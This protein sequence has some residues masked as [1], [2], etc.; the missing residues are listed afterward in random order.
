VPGPGEDPPVGPSPEVPRVSIDAPE[1][2]SDS[3]RSSRFRVSWLATSAAGI[4][5]YDVDYRIGGGKWRSLARGTQVTSRLFRGSPGQTYGFRVRARSRDLVESG[6]VEDTT[7]VPL[8]DRSRRLAYS[9]GWRRAS[10]RGAYAR[11]ISAGPRHSSVRLRFR[12]SR[13][14][15]IAPR[16]GAGGRV[17][18][19]ID[20]QRRKVIHL[21]GAAGSR[22]VV[23]RSGRL[24]RKRVH[25][26]VVRVLSRGSTRLDA[27]AVHR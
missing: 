26:L 3:S 14:A 17:A 16:S 9:K 20:G 13:V 12:G 18:V 22:R 25:T 10:D 27:V 15:L 6:Y 1:Y 23:F 5:A 11:T 19:H 24:S 7:V 4:A 21:R 8:D 2:A